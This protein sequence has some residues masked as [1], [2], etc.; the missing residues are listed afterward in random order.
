MSSLLLGLVRFIETARPGLLIVVGIALGAM[1]TVITLAAAVSL[2]GATASSMAGPG[3]MLPFLY[4]QEGSF[5]TQ[6]EG[7][8]FFGLALFVAVFSATTVLSLA[9]LTFIVAGL[10]RLAGSAFTQRAPQH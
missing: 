7:G 1:S 3:D 2:T 8:G 4:L 10:I 9:A 6:R 5:G